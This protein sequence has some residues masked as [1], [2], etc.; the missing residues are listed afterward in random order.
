MKSEKRIWVLAASLLLCAA[1][2]LAQ[3]QPQ[4][5]TPRN[6]SAA[7]PAAR[8][9]SPSDAGDASLNAPQAEP[10]THALSGGEQ[11][12]LG[13][14]G[15][16]RN[17]LD[18]AL[19]L[20]EMG[21]A[22]AQYGLGP[23]QL[24]SLTMFG[25]SLNFNH[26]W[27]HYQ[28]AGFYNGGDSVAVPALYGSTY[29]WYQDV[30]IEQDMNWNRWT[31]RLRDDFLASPQAGFGG[32]N[33]GG[34]GLLGQFNPGGGIALSSLS[35]GFGQNGTILTGQAMRLSNTALGEADYAVSRRSTLTFSGTYG[36]MHFLDPGYIDNHLVNAQVGYDYTLSPKDTIAL[37]AGYVRSGY[38]GSAQITES[39]RLNVAFGRKITGRLAFQLTGG[40]MRVRLYNFVPQ[41]APQW[42]WNLNTHITYELRRT[43][44][45]LSYAHDTT[46][47]SGVFFGARTDVI[48]ASLH[49]R[50]TKMWT[51]TTN[52]G[53]ARNVSLVT[54]GPAASNFNNWYGG[55]NI[56][57][58]VGRHA[59]I[60]FNYGLQ[61][62]STNVIV[63][64]VANCGTTTLGQTFGMSLTWHP[65]PI[66]VE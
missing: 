49:R 28:L 35:S 42:T 65:R 5:S 7:V 6:P 14:L 25:G 23:H 51:F 8:G 21:D 30:A 24:G 10:D 29:N 48:T 58:Q 9:V 20:N 4:N 18:I 54:A 46:T 12:S 3:G 53:Y 38:A 19:I 66:I 34:P 36:L 47:G 13:A 15:G 32:Q 17:V 27:R 2:T 33:M 56:S 41:V 64:P 57:R 26:S 39:D 22:G 1:N 37:I 60:G 50:L 31:V 44:Y 61:Q 55:A 63:C 11:L 40:P 62:Q 59:T 43:G 16:A 45:S 52:A